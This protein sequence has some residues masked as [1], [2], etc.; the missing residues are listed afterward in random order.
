MVVNACVPKIPD[1]PSWASG[2]T[3]GLNAIVRVGTFVYISLQAANTGNT[4][5]SSPS[6]WQ[7][8]KYATIQ[9]NI[10]AAINEGRSGP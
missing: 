4:P 3:Y 10:I 8:T 1:A 2:T 9:E 5:A 6:W 7:E